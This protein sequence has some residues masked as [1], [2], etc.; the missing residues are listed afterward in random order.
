[1]V[2]DVLVIGG[3]GR[4]SNPNEHVVFLSVSSPALRRIW[5]KRDYSIKKYGFTP[6]ISL[7]RGD[8]EALATALERFFHWEKPQ[9]Y[10]AEFRIVST[11]S[12]QGE[13]FPRD[14]PVA[15]YPFHRMLRGNIQPNLLS[16]LEVAVSRAKR[17]SSESALP[18][19]TPPA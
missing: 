16:R 8:D 7:Y 15:R 5:W 13:M 9:I 12:K 3:V 1:M 11:V 6:H 17:R 10:C 2:N 19:D 18:K 4:F 14:V